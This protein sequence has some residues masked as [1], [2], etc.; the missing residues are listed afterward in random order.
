MT[1]TEYWGWLRKLC[2]SGREQRALLATE[3]EKKSESE[4]D[5]LAV[6]LHDISSIGRQLKRAAL[7]RGRYLYSAGWPSRWAMAYISSLLIVLQIVARRGT[8]VIY[9]D[10]DYTSHFVEYSSVHIYVCWN[11]WFI[12]FVKMRCWCCNTIMSHKSDSSK[13]QPYAVHCMW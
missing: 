8:K 1:G 9:I 7:N 10:T 5:W 2:V 11:C 4:S 3:L 6:L 13:T 12:L